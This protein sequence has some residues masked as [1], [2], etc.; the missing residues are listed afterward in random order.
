LVANAQARRSLRQGGNVVVIERPSVH[1][2]DCMFMAAAA[3]ALADGRAEPV[4]YTG[5]TTFLRRTELLSRLGRRATSERFAAAIDRVAS[6][7][8]AELPQGLRPRENAAGTR[9]VAQAA[10]WV[11][12]A[13]GV[14]HPQE[15]ALFHSMLLA[16][17]PTQAAFPAETDVELAGSWSAGAM[18]SYALRGGID[19]GTATLSAPSSNLH[20]FRSPGGR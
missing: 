15:E 10:V 3:M 13:D 14:L 2:L 1:T 12:F 11:A 20:V 17:E 4:E 8:N 9:L 18:R 19:K 16:F 6:Q 7:S 5:F